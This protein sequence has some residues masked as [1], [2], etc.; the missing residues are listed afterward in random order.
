MKNFTLY[1]FSLLVLCHLCCSCPVNS[2]CDSHGKKLADLRE[3]YLQGET[4]PNGVGASNAVIVT[5]PPPAMKPT[6]AKP[7]SG[8]TALSHSVILLLA[9]LVVG[10]IQYS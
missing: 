2:V 8:G 7:K 10:K 4:T 6:T 1:V 3:D 5:N 9:C